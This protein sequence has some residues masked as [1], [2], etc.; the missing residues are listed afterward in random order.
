V[1]Q[2]RS[3]IE[4]IHWKEAKSANTVKSFKS[5]LREHPRGKYATQAKNNIEELRWKIANRAYTVASFKNYL[6]MYP[7]GRHAAKAQA[8]IAALQKALE[9]GER[10]LEGTVKK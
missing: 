6:K 2:A 3:N 7:A 1:A 5:Y 9:Q 8:N 10:V 4:E